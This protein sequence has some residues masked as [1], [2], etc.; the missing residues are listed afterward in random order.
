MNT[1]QEKPKP[2]ARPTVQGDPNPNNNLPL[3]GIDYE[4]LNGENFQAYEKITQGLILNQKYD[5][6]MWKATSVIKKRFN[7]DT[8][9]VDEYVAGIQLNGNKPIQ[10][11][12]IKA[13]DALL[14]NSQVS[15]AIADGNNSKYYLLAKP[16]KD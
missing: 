2:G 5:F 15:R 8:G 11:T 6:E 10:T 1:K 14:L 16:K 7:E 12:R 4:N 9:G 13:K 3:D